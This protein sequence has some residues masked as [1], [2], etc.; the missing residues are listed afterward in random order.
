MVYW[1]PKSSPEWC[2]GEHPVFSKGDKVWLWPE[3]WQSESKPC[4]FLLLGRVALD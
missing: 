1:H 4:H 3:H 2:E